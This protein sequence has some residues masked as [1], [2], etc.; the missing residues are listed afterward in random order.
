MF[1]EMLARVKEK[2]AKEEKRKR[3]AREDFTALLKESRDIKL[4]MSWEDAQPL[5]EKQPEYKA[6]SHFSMNTGR[7]TASTLRACLLTFCMYDV[8]TDRAQALLPCCASWSLNL[9]PRVVILAVC[10][11]RNSAFRSESGQENTISAWPSLYVQSKGSSERA[12]LRCFSTTLPA[13]H[14]YITCVG[15]CLRR[16]ALMATFAC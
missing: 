10:G 14:P 1:D 16:A 11:I 4:D 12:N 6:V 9:L 13:R 15:R 7:I 2:V 3:R 5:L 8:M